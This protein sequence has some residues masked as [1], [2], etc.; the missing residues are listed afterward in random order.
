MPCL[1]F[2]QAA[3]IA[4]DKGQGFANK[5]PYLDPAKESSNDPT[6]NNCSNGL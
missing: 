1:H 2:N 3:T 6:P 5:N 4:V